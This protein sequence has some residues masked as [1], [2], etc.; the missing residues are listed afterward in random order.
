MSDSR[1]AA[2]D[3]SVGASAN[4]VDSP[5][6]RLSKRITWSPRA[7]EQLAPLVGV[8]R[9]LAAE[10][11]DHQQRRVGGVA[12]R[13]VV[14]LAVAVGGPSRSP[15]HGRDHGRVGRHAAQIHASRGRVA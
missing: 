15:C 11:V 2:P 9:A 6:S 1:Y 3:A 12:E 4:D 8:V 5:T 10:A 13:V 7:D 14:E